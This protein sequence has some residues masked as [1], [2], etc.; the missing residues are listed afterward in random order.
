VTARLLFVVS[1]DDVDRYHLL[2]R[3]FVL[4]RRFGER[5]QRGGLAAVER[6]LNGDR[7][8]REVADD[9]QRL[10]WAIVRR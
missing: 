9:V 4:D 5:R 3:A 2:K 1:R 10:G 8:R 6:R 7:R